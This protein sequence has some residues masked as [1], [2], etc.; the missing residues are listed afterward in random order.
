LHGDPASRATRR[1]GDERDLPGEWL[2]HVGLP[3]VDQSCNWCL[4]LRQ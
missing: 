1:S 4:V 2:V 3:Q